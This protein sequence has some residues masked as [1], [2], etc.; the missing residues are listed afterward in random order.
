MRRNRTCLNLP[1]G[2][3]IENN[4][5]EH[6]WTKVREDAWYDVSDHEVRDNNAMDDLLNDGTAEVVIEE[7]GLTVQVIPSFDLEEGDYVLMRWGF[8]YDIDESLL[9]PNGSQWLWRVAGWTDTD[10][11]L[12]TVALD[13]PQ[14]MLAMVGFA[15]FGEHIGYDDFA[16]I[17]LPVTAATVFHYVE[18]DEDHKRWDDEWDWTYEYTFV[19]PPAVP[20]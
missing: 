18:K 12:W 20:A 9:D 15:E 6:L 11:G 4:P 3:T 14:N 1:E 8:W 16:P 19:D 10:D 7:T 2:T 13:A 17:L 5:G